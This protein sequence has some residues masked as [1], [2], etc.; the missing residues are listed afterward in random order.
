VKSISADDARVL[1]ADLVETGR[2]VPSLG[3]AKTG[4]AMPVAN[5]GGGQYSWLVPVVQGGDMMAGF[6]EVSI[7]GTLLRSSRLGAPQPLSAWV[8]TDEIGKV[9]AEHAREGEAVGEP[10]L[11]YDGVPTRT[12]WAVAL[13]VS[14]VRVATVYVAGLSSYRRDTSDGAAPDLDSID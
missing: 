9:A 14:S 8:D 7:D 11:T 1:A 10:T 4:I 2:A 13:S 3:P 5:P 6:V 12:A